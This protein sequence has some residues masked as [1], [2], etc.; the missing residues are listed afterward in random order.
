MSNK[1]QINDLI[2]NTLVSHIRKDDICIDATLGKGRDS[3]FLLQHI[4]EGFLYGFD[5]QKEAV[6]TSRKLL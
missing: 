4:P 1:Y 3:L 5:L 2:R 6:E